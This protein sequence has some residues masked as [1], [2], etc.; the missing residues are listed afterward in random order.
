MK[1]SLGVILCGL[2]LFALAGFGIGLKAMQSNHGPIVAYAEEGEEEEPIDTGEEGGEEEPSEP[3]EPEVVELPCKVVISPVQ[4]G[5][6]YVDIKE[7]N[8][9]DICIITAKHDLLYKV[10]SVLANGVTLIED[11]AISGQ[12]CFALVEGENVITA[13][14][15]V[16]EELCGIMSDII[17]EAGDK[18]WSR[19]FTVENAITIVKWLLDGGILI[20]LI[21]YYVKDKRLE[22]KLEEKV[23]QTINGIIPDTTKNTVL[24]TVEQ[25][26]T[27]MFTEVKSDYVELMRAMTVFAK[28]M[29]LAQENTPDS[30][31]AI[32]DELSG[33]KIGD[34]DTLGEVRKSIEEMVARHTKAYEETLAAI[35][36]LG[37]KQDGYVGETKPVETEPKEEVTDEVVVN[38]QATE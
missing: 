7:G 10:S 31:R 3:E 25:V 21:R 4:H 34:L 18:D 14:F 28:C 29:A 35:K 30:R 2:G 26:I 24:T 5:S 6:V 36:E 32:L 27:P 12:F 37:L 23:Q 22:K 33:L 19:L 38:K 8:V 16:D 9:G 11:E 1:K 17:Q 15:V 20:A 13:S